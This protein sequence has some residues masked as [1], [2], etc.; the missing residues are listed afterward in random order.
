MPTVIRKVTPS[1]VAGRRREVVQAVHWQVQ[2]NAN[3]WSPPTDLYETESEYIIRVEVAGMRDVDID[4]TVDDDILV[5]SG[6]RPDLPE[7]RAYH[8]MEIRFGKFTTAVGLPGA[9]DLDRARA[10]YEDGFLV[11]TLPRQQSG[12]VRVEE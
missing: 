7:R 2:M 4:V 5:I 6:V 10:E 9:V 1:S 3:L 11:V 8:Q 12:Q